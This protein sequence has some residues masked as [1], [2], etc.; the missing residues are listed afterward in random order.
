MYREQSLRKDCV[1]KQNQ[2]LDLR[3]FVHDVLARNRIV[4]PHLKLIGHGALVLV[5]SVKVA[6]AGR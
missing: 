5:R 2:L 4:L 6:S 1:L 3:F